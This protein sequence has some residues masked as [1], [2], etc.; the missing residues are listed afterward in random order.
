MT[1]SKESREIAER[2]VAL[3][4]GTDGDHAGDRA[5]LIELAGNEVGPLE[6][7]REVLVRRIRTRSDD[8]PATSGLALLNA[9]LSKFGKRDDV[10]WQPRKWRIPH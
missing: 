10:E 6:Q 9:T 4:T 3:A 5:A 1:P 2:A 7:A 8:F